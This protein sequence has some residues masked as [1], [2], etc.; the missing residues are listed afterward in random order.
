MDTLPSRESVWSALEHLDPP[1]SYPSLDNLASYSSSGEIPLILDFPLASLPSYDGTRNSLRS[2]HTFGPPRVT[3]TRTGDDAESQKIDDSPSP[4][5]I[6]RISSATTLNDEQDAKHHSLPA[7]F[8]SA[9]SSAN[10]ELQ[11]L[12]LP[13]STTEST[14]PSPRFA[15]PSL[16]SSDESRVQSPAPS[17]PDLESEHEYDPRAS[18]LHPSVPQQPL[19]SKLRK[20]V[21]SLV[22]HPHPHAHMHSPPSPPRPPGLEHANPSPSSVPHTHDSPRLSK[23]FHRRTSTAASIPSPPPPQSPI[24]EITLSTLPSVNS[25]DEWRFAS[26]PIALSWLKDTTVELLIDQE[27][28]RSTRPAFVLKG[29]TGPPPRADGYPPTLTDHLL[30]GRADFMPVQRKEL[31]FHHSSLDALPVLRRVYVGGDE[32]HDYVGREARLALKGT[33]AYTVRGAEPVHIPSHP[34][35]LSQTRGL[36][37]LPPHAELTWQFDYFV[38]ERRRKDGQPWKAEGGEKALAPLL[39][40]CAP[41]VLAPAQA[42]KVRIVQVVRKSVAGKLVAERI[43]PPM[44]AGAGSKAAPA[45]RARGAENE[46]G[47]ANRGHRRARSQAQAIEVQVKTTVMSSSASVQ[48]PSRAPMRELTNAPAPM[49]AL[50]RNIVPKE[51]LAALFD[52]PDSGRPLSLPTPPSP[53]R[54]RLRRGSQY[55]SLKGS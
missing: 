5:T 21:S 32:A 16:L 2:V 45:R 37:N 15:P 7:S 46:N 27:G 4:S 49:P 8:L 19:K 33:G 25:V 28:F 22:P 38:N 10:S 6:R 52:A 12:L 9:A 34:L 40:A 44:L 18:L 31:V 48:I 35:P 50:A 55:G 24:P 54:P 42:R 20:A 13:T 47:Q 3:L 23:L 30:H 29:Y 14:L 11:A 17:T 26:L 43:A 36:P 41:G 1:P 51:L 39:F 53:E